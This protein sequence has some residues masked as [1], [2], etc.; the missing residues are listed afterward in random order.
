MQSGFTLKSALG[1]IAAVLI[2]SLVS[3]AY[4]ERVHLPALPVY[5]IIG[6]AVALIIAAEIR[7]KGPKKRLGRARTRRAPGYA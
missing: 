7:G 3:A 1:A 2:I 6:M 4:Y 5:T